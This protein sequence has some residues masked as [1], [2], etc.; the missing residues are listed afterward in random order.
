MSTIGIA[1]SEPRITNAPCMPEDYVEVFEI[2]I[3]D[4]RP[5]LYRTMLSVDL[6]EPSGR[7]IITPGAKILRQTIFQDSIPWIVVTLF[8]T[9]P[10]EP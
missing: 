5:E 8:D 10:N 1:A 7:P 2:P 3:S 4:L 6:T 9:H